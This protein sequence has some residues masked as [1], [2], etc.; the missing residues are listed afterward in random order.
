MKGCMSVVR[1]L[2]LTGSLLMKELSHSVGDRFLFFQVTYSS[3][4]SLG[5]LSPKQ[6][7]QSFLL[8]FGV[9]W[10]FFWPCIMWDLRSPTRG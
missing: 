5:S 2:Y 6:K 1:L 7:G 3:S 9:L 4:F 10:G 8:L